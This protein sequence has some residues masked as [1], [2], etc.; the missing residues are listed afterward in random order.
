VTHLSFFEAEA[1]ARW[2]GARLPTEHEWEVAAG[3][4][5][6]E[7]NLLES[8]RL[9][10]APALPPDRPE[11]ARCP[12]QLIGD[13]WEWTRSD[14]GPYPGYRPPEGALGEYNG[15]FM[16]GQYVLRG[17]C[18]V[19]PGSHIRRTY[20]NFFHPEERWMFSGLRLAR[21]LDRSPGRTRRR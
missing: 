12:R 18:C 8:G 17:G 13:C 9:H 5:S 3:E 14:Y 10:P 6:M 16:C 21:D 15:K 19:T 1:Y 11:I 7:G 20:R 4:V 2:A